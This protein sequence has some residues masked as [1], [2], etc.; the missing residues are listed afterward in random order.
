MAGFGF[1]IGV[2]DGDSLDALAVQLRNI[3]NYITPQVHLRALTKA[4]APLKKEIYNTTPVRS[5]KLRKTLR[6]ARTKFKKQGQ[7]QV[8]V[9]FR[10]GRDNGEPLSGFIAH[11]FEYGTVKMPASPFM[12]PAD[13]K[14][15]AEQERVYLEELQKQVDKI[16]Q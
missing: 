1:N 5:G 14:T 12:R 9:G 2:D 4:A 13:A 6:V 8:V 11:F 10:K 7:H 16:L 3:P 15:K